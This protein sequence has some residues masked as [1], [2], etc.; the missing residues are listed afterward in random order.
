MRSGHRLWVAAACVCALGTAN[1]RPFASVSDQ[2]L[3][4]F[5]AQKAAFQ[6]AAGDA[7][8]LRKAFA[9]LLLGDA[10]STALELAEGGIVVEPSA[11]ERYRAEARALA[12]DEPGA[13][14]AGDTDSGAPSPALR[15]SLGRIAAGL[16][17]VSPERV[18]EG[19]SPGG[20]PISADI[21][22]GFAFA[23]GQASVPGGL[24]LIARFPV[25]R[26]VGDRNPNRDL[27]FGVDGGVMVSFVNTGLATALAQGF[28]PTLGG[29]PRRQEGRGVYAE[30][31]S[32][33]GDDT[34][35]MKLIELIG[36]NYVT[37]QIGN[38]SVEIGTRLTA[39]LNDPNY[40]RTVFTRKEG[41][42]EDAPCCYTG[43]Q[44]QYHVPN[45]EREPV[46]KNVGRTDRVALRF[47]KERG[48]GFVL[49]GARL[50]SSDKRINGAKS[51]RAGLT[52][53]GW[54]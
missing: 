27:N 21:V 1:A 25:A 3:A 33:R 46:T 4:A 41:T 6:Q 38:L 30:L 32:S 45:P 53:R 42:P 39:V 29:L 47:G 28:Q 22:M 43:W 36:F 18:F 8:Q 40:A 12:S 24:G 31:D 2:G 14:P 34:K 11:L 49:E 35:G 26:I 23:Q 54:N 52:L 48:V 37:R 7:A 16:Q 19:V 13:A 10:A 9:A 50:S 5:F 51:V 44:A 15:D 17:A 20:P